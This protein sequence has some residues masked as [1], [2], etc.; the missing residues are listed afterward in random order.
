MSPRLERAKGGMVGESDR[1]LRVMLCSS[2]AF[3][4]LC[5]MSSFSDHHLKTSLCNCDAASWMARA[6][7]RLL[8]WRGL[9]VAWWERAIVL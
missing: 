7:I 3:A 6:V 5:L 9:R 4:F 8:A 1:L 2:S